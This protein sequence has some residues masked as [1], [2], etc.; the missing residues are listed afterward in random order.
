MKTRISVLLTLLTLL[1]AACAPVVTVAPVPT[2]FLPVVTQEPAVPVVGMA[3]VQ[4]VEVQILESDPLQVNVIARGQL[5]DAGCTTISSVEQVRDGNTFKIVLMTTT[6]PL[7]LCALALTPFDRVISLNVANLPPAQYTVDVNGV[8]QSFE[9]LTRDLAKFKQELVSALNARN[10]DLL[11]TMLDESLVIASW[12]SEGSPYTADAALEQLKSNYLSAAPVLVADPNKDLNALLGGM[13]PMSLLGLDVGSN[14][15]LYVSGWGLDG[16]DEAILYMN[17]RL[18]GGLYW[19][20]LL[21]AKGGFAANGPIVIDPIDTNTYATSVEYVMAQTNVTI[22]AGPGSSYSVIGEVAGGQIA[23]VL[24]TNVYGSWWRVV[25]PDDKAG[26]CWISGDPALTQPT[27]APHTDQPLPPGD[28][29]PTSVKYIQAQQ[30]VQIY[31]GPATQYNVLGSLAA[32]QIAKVTGVSADGKWW[33]VICPDDTVGSCW[34]MARSGYT[35][36]TTA[37]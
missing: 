31:G 12:R 32:G 33:R 2:P 8:K 6:N 4:N 29:Q 35:Q 26:S 9:L 17:Y 28:P 15:A 23:K 7:A 14:F 24:G 21:V 20:G 37:P 36:P 30:D 27:T 22:Y 25:C 1:M 5:P 11:R 34:V 16:K 19:H 3:V 13:D 10:F 18:D